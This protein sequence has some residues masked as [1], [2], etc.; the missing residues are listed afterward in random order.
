MCIYL[1]PNYKNDK[2][3]VGTKLALSMSNEHMI[4]LFTSLLAKFSVRLFSNLVAKHLFHSQSAALCRV[5]RR[6]PSKVPV[7]FR[8][9][10]VVCY[11]NGHPTL[12]R[13]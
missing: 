3:I 7:T 1:D 12:K 8:A 10:A 2:N 13:W 4:Q 6:Q 11:H 5:V 9:F